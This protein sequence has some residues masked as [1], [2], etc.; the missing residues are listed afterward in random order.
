MKTIHRRHA[1]HDQARAHPVSPVLDKRAQ[2]EVLFTS[3]YTTLPVC[4]QRAKLSP[5]STPPPTSPRRSSL[6][7]AN[8]GPTISTGSPPSSSLK[9]TRPD[10]SQPGR[11][12]CL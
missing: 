12:Q 7:P 5:R 9:A 11:A 6:S 1:R 2:K 3:C 8:P 4:R 10:G